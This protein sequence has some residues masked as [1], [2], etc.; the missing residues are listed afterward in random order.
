M[1]KPFRTH[2]AQSHQ[3]P[4]LSPFLYDLGAATQALPPAAVLPEQFYSP[5]ASAVSGRGEVAL[6][7]AVLEDAIDCFQKLLGKTDR[8]SQRLVREAEEWIFS[9]DLRWPFS[10]LNICNVLGIDPDY[11]RRGLKR[12]Q[13]HRFPAPEKSKPHRTAAPPPIPAAA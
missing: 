1:S 7:R 9:E 6:M 5:A 10:F 11:V 13:Q 8:R 2:R 3:R 4:V 12:W